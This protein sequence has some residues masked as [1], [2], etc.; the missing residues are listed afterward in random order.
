MKQ[1]KTRQKN[2][3]IGLDG[4]RTLA[5]IGVLLYHTFP[6]Q[7]PGGYFGVILFFVLTGYLAGITMAKHYDGTLSSI[8]LYYKKRILR[9]YP[10]LLIVIFTTI[11][12][13][14][15]IDKTYLVNADHETASILLGYNNYWQLHMNADYFTKV[16]DNSPFTHFWYI[17]IQI[18]FELIWPW[19]YAL[20]MLIKKKAGR[21]RML[22]T[23]FGLTAVTALIMPVRAFMHTPAT[24]LYYDSFCRF[25]AIL[26]GVSSG[27]LHKENRHLIYLHS[28]SGMKELVYL[29][30]FIL[31]SIILYLKAPGSAMWVYE[32][33]MFVYTLLCVCMVEVVS[34]ENGAGRL[35]NLTPFRYISKYSYEIYLWQYPVLFVCG[36]LQW[37]HTFGFYLLQIGIIVLLSIWLHTVTGM[38]PD[39]RN[40]LKRQPAKN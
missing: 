32:I 27:L 33:G 35:L 30:V 14:F 4:L 20:F 15:F 37:S 17:A 25:Y 10:Q 5:L 19:L 16:T 39:I 26:A 21:N 11:G 12:I 2:N 24:V 9:I 22:L 40:V 28:K 3:I 8:L 13:I 6:F 29:F 23:A 31:V 38:K 1:T 36:I 18:Q 7:I 34:V